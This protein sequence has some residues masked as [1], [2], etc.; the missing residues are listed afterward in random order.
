MTPEKGKHKNKENRNS[1]VRHYDHWIKNSQDEFN[2]RF[3]MAEESV[4]LK[5]E[6]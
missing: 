2:N 6:Q 3:E 5:I 4:T 1:K